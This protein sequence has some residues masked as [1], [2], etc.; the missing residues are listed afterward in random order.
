MESFNILESLQAFAIPPS[1]LM[2]VIYRILSICFVLSVTLLVIL[3]LDPLKAN[4]QV[5]YRRPENTFG[6]LPEPVLNNALM[7][8]IFPTLP[9]LCAL[10]V[11]SL[12]VPAVGLRTENA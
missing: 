3:A 4:A 6:N 12:V 8:A 10:I 2:E 5:V 9:N 11:I 7:E 1:V